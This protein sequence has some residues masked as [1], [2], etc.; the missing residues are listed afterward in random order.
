MLWWAS[1]QNL[2]VRKLQMFWQQWK[3]G[4]LL[5]PHQLLLSVGFGVSFSSFGAEMKQEVC[6]IEQWTAGQ[7]SSGNSD[8][9]FSRLQEELHVLCVPGSINSG[10]IWE[11]HGTLCG[12]RGHKTSVWFGILPK[13]AQIQACSWGS[14]IWHV[15]GSTGKFTLFFTPHLFFPSQPFCKM[16]SARL[17]TAFSMEQKQTQGWLGVWV[18]TLFSPMGFRPLFL[19]WG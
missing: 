7:G 17:P 9:G 10:L 8:L 12:A 18:V 1:L 6:L 16:L 15:L 11:G 3:F 4:I 14:W 13:P 19:H 5:L 2:H